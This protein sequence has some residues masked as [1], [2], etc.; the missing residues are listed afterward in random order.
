[1]SRLPLA[2]VPSGPANPADL[3]MQAVMHY[4]QGDHDGAR[5]QLKVVLRKLPRHFD[6]LHLMGLLEAQ[7]GHYKDADKLLR[8]ALM[9]N[10]QSAEAHSN[11]GNVLRDMGELEPAV[12]CYDTALRLN[13][14]YPNAHNNR[15]IALTRLGRFEDAVKSYTA[16]ITIDQKFAAAYYNRGIAQTQLKHFAQAVADYDAAISL[17]PGMLM[18]QIDRASALVE[19]GRFDDAYA[20]YKRVLTIDPRAVNAHFN[21]GLALTRQDRHDDALASFAT[22]VAI[23]P[24]FAA[25]YDATGNVLTALGQ[26]ERALESYDKAIKAAPASAAF[27][28]NRGAALQKLNRQKEALA[29]F[30]AALRASPGFAPAHGNRARALLALGQT[31][32]ARKSFDRAIEADPSSTDLRANRGSAAMA[33][34]QHEAAIEDFEHVLAADPA[35]PYAVGNLI[36]CKMHAC[37]WRGLNELVDRARAGIAAGKPAVLP[38]IATAITDDSGLLYKSADIWAKD[39][40]LNYPALPKAARGD[41]D[42]IRIAYVSADFRDHPVAVQAVQLFELHD[43]SRFE[44]TAISYGPNDRSA[45]RSRLEKAFDAFCD[46]SDLSDQAAAE[47]VAAR[48]IDIAIDLTG[49]TD[50]C[51]PGILARRP[52]P[53]QVSFLGYSSTMA[54]DFIDYIIGDRIVIPEAGQK[55]FS[56]RIV[57][58]PDMF[59]VSD[60]TRVISDAPLTR[61]AAGLPEHG[62][63]FCCFNNRHKITPEMFAIWTRVLSRVENSVLWLSA[64]SETSTRNLRAAAQQHGIAPERLIFAGRVPSLADHLARHR[65]ADLFLDTLPYNAHSTTSDALWAGLPV[66][67]LSGRQLCRPCRWKLTVSG[68]APRTRDSVV[69]RLRETRVAACPKPGNSG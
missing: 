34:R 32:D 42:K 2:P 55:F 49:Y 43:R 29:S 57:R 19:L 4:R 27:H 15:A 36:H 66:A 3:F 60:T 22:A 13:P 9:L 63:V 59:F 30:D 10:P 51:R 67:D 35:Y 54:V 44:V 21:L 5:R 69:R 17:E 18:A 38:L 64:G 68:R 65:L 23:D 47:T 58:L 46:V 20:A 11:R 40:G 7:R 61:A 33:L 8:Q 56:E 12:G 41:R 37:D 62:F 24:G 53:V 25:A 31:A 39:I 28:N 1:M 16:A 26:V 45:L 50:F 52:A 14:N 6:A 48:G